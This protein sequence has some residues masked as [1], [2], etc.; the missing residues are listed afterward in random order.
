MNAS[1]EQQALTAILVKNEDREAISLANSQ[2][3]ETL[4]QLKDYPCENDQDLADLGE[5]LQSVRISFKSLEEKRT[6]I[7]KPLNAAKQ[8]VDA[9][10]KPAKDLLESA[11]STIRAKINDYATRKENARLATLAEARRLA[12]MNQAP[13]VTVTAPVVPAPQAA[14]ASVYFKPSW[15]YE[16]VNPEL[17]PRQFLAVNDAAVRSH[18]APFAH[19]DS[20]PEVPGLK[21]TKTQTMVAK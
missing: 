18:L 21:F 9:M 2:G 13:A 12:A 16:I 19:A 11:E 7:T 14:T 20:V 5:I 1:T 8:A 4:V 15:T 10:F 17:I 3:Q 6:S